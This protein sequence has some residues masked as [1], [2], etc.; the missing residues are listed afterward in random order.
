LTA[1]GCLSCPDANSV[2]HGEIIVECNSKLNYSE[3]QESENGQ[4]QSKLCDGLSVLF[5]PKA[6][7]HLGFPM[8]GGGPFMRL[9]G[10]ALA[11]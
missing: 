7:L 10:P 11:T 3:E 2:R 4:N 5:F 8:E 6:L 1:D 9:E